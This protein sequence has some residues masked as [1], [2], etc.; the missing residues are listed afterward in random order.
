MIE[1]QGTWMPI[2][3]YKAIRPYIEEVVEQVGRPVS[4]PELHAHL[5]EVI[6]S[7]RALTRAQIG[8]HI[9][10]SKILTR[11]KVGR[12]IY[13]VSQKVFDKFMAGNLVEVK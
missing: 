2:D 1:K 13:V 8:G 9:S 3:I 4:Y 12:D 11:F 10:R 5:F 7:R 6:G